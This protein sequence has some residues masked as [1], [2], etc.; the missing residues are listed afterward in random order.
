MPET[1]EQRSQDARELLTSKN[2]SDKMRRATS[3]RGEDTF[4][5][6]DRQKKTPLEIQQILERKYPDMLAKFDEFDRAVAELKENNSHLSE[7]EFDLELQKL[8][9]EMDVLT[10][11]AYSTTGLTREK[12]TLDR[13]MC[14]TEMKTWDN[15]DSPEKMLKEKPMFWCPGKRDIGRIL[16]IAL[17]AR[18]EAGARP[19]PIRIADVGG[20]NGALGELLVKYAREQDVAVEY[21]VIDTDA[22]TVDKAREHYAT[23]T[24]EMH[25][26]HGTGSDY[27]IEL[28]KDQTLLAALLR[29]RKQ[30]T[31]LYNRRLRDIQTMLK[32]FPTKVETVQDVKVWEDNFKK[33][34]V[35]LERE[36]GLSGPGGIRKL[37]DYEVP[38]TAREGVEILNGLK[39]A[40]Y[41]QILVP[42]RE[43]VEELTK[44]I[45]QLQKDIPPRID[46]T[47]NSWML[48]GVDYTKDVRALN[49][50]AIAYALNANGSTGVEF[51]SEHDLMK[52][53]VEEERSYRAG[54]V[55]QESAVW[56]LTTYTDLNAQMG[57]R[58]ESDY[59][60]YGE[61][62]VQLRKNMSAGDYEPESCGLTLG[63]PYPWEEKKGKRLVKEAEIRYSGGEEE[64]EEDD[65]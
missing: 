40:V 23:Q 13:R 31:E 14:L 1:R 42:G 21:V 4:M 20:G 7:E 36:Y 38:E 51:L 25:F 35:V 52:H 54:A 61:L 26:F 28:F 63:D 8:E 10:T 29:E 64:D 32:L 43:K 49:G 59:A 57:R 33:L 53:G 41:N 56:K 18:A 5:S 39:D 50:G 58:N 62:R 34:M 24:P 22:E 6:F 17:H 30:M 11:M 16:A 9:D 46:L 44:R 60:A 2:K 48:P 27:T 19:G 15:I 37:S 47:L 45:E 65:E 55:Y 12:I 3:E